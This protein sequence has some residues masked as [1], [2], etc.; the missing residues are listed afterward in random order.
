MKTLR[1]LL[2]AAVFAVSVGPARADAPLR[3]GDQFDLSIGGVPSEEMSQINRNYT[4]DGEGCLNLSY[5]GKVQVEG[6]T[7][8]EIQSSI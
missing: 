3:K 6:K 5:I 8:S 2:L 7:V 4:V 1:S